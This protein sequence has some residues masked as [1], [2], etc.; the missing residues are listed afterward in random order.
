MEID[1]AQVARAWHLVH[2]GYGEV[3]RWAARKGDRMQGS[4]AQSPIE[5]VQFAHAYSDWDFYIQPNPTKKRHGVRCSAE[6][7]T[8]WRWFLIDIDPTK[9][10]D[11]TDGSVERVVANIRAALNS[12]AGTPV[13]AVIVGSGRGVQLW[14]PLAASNYEHPIIPLCQRYWL[15]RLEGRRTE[16]G[17]VI[18]A[19]ASAD[20]PRL[21]RCPGTVNRKTG[22]R[23]YIWMGS[24]PTPNE[25]LAQ[26][27]VGWT[28]AKDKAP[29]T[30]REQVT[31]VQTNVWQAAVAYMTNEGANYLTF[32][33]TEPGRHRAAC[34]AARSLA[35]CGVPEGEIVVALS[36]GG[37]L[38]RPEITD[39]GYLERTARDAVRLAARRT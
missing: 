33:A 17:W 29:P 13:N 23:A 3:V 30:P 34:A 32:G 10:N 7:V 39:R 4:W 9:E 35:E 27:I 24:D 2:T 6:D 11:G 15:A 28:P 38:C 18:D 37:L 16:P 19:S 8:R 26:K 22:R 21:F 36:V 1:D 5:L 25:G 12:Y 31:G 20:L 14:V